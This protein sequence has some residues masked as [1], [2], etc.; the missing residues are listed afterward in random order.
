MSLYEQLER[1]K[2]WLLTLQHKLMPQT[3]LSQFAKAIQ[4]HEGYYKGSRSYRNNNPANF[5]STPYTKTLGAIDKD[6]QGF[7]IFPSYVVGFNA[8]KTFLQDACSG[9]LKR[10]K[11]TMNLYE[12][13]EVYAPSFENDSR[14]YAEFVAKYIGIPTDTQIKSFL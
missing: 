8:L 12:F 10:Y 6:P 14:A 9:R 2:Q 7:C 4:T 3:K 1:A 11:G 5:R 13:F